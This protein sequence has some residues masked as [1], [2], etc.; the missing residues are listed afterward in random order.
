MFV[1]V[2]VLLIIQNLL[3]LF[4]SR[5]LVHSGVIYNL[6]LIV[7]MHVNYCLAAI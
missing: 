5:R 2:I 1:T 6:F 4:G 7:E 3:F